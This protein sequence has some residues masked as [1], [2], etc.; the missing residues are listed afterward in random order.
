MDTGVRGQFRCFFSGDD[1]TTQIRSSPHLHRVAHPHNISEMATP[2]SPV[3]REHGTGKKHH[4][5]N[6]ISR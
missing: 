4:F 2:P 1:K 3:I 6:Y 5:A